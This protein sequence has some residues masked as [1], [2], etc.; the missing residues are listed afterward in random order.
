MLA[1]LEGGC[2]V[3]VGAFA[4]RNADR[5][6]RLSAGVFDLDGSQAVRVELEALADD[7]AAAIA[8]GR[9]AAARLR[10]NGAEDIL[11]RVRAASPITQS[12]PEP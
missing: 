12:A 4:R 11:A 2:Q 8:L 7:E 5:R 6:L 9:D 10:D 3:P 1:E